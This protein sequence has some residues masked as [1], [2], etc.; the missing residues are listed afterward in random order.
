MRIFG[1]IIGGIML[2][3]SLAFLAVG[4]YVVRQLPGGQLRIT[5]A[6][7]V[8]PTAAIS[9]GVPSLDAAITPAGQDT[10]VI[11][12]F[13]SS[14]GG[15]EFSIKLRVRSTNNKPVFI[16]VAPTAR[17]EQY[18][19]A[20]PRDSV[21]SIEGSDGSSPISFKLQRAVGS[22]IVGT[23]SRIKVDT[24]PDTA[25]R[26]D[27]KAVRKQLAV[28]VKRAQQQI[29]AVPIRRARPRPA[30][31]PIWSSSVS[32]PGW[33]EF[34]WKLSARTLQESLV[35]MNADGSPAVEVKSGVAMDL[36]L[37]ASIFS[38][39]RWI[40]IIGTIVSTVILVLVLRPRRRATGASAADT[41][42]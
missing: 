17:V 15:P 29:A 22:Q 1:G 31:V 26:P 37:I 27:A 12:T 32:G 16:G 3:I 14:S 5:P 24:P 28:E 4:W 23:A 7:L 25:P 13:T 38:G 39:V 35:I 36:G 41:T 2:L 40:G 21:V 33:Q 11:E 34:T 9:L 20:T 10:G 30:R 19:A 8:S 18:L 6:K 42:S